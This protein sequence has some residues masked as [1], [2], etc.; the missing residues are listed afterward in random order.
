MQVTLDLP[1]IPGYE[2]T[3]EFRPPVK[4]E[5]C[6]MFGKPVREQEKYNTG[7]ASYPIMRVK[8]KSKI[9]LYQWL[10]NHNTN[11]DGDVE[12]CGYRICIATE[13]H[14]VSMCKEFGWT[15]KKFNGDGIVA[16]V[17]L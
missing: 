9:A 5:V 8:A 15:F 1:E 6:L 4:G 16:V 17:H 10:I 12:D 14:I 2:Y 11:N 7:N 13:D 3:G